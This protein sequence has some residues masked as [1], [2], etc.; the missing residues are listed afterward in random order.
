M[1][2][3]APRIPFSPADYLAWEAE[4]PTRHEYL[5]GE[6]FAMT[7]ASD[8]HVTIALNLGSLLRERLRGSPCRAYMSDMKLQVKACNAFFYPDVLV[9]CHTDDRALRQHK[10]RPSFLAEVLS[11]TT[12][13]LD[14]GEKF[15]C[16]RS[17]A[18]LKEYL[19]IDPGRFTAELF[20]LDESGHWVLY[21]FSLGDELELR[22]LGLRF[23]VTLLFED[24]EP[25][26]DAVSHP[27]N[28]ESSVE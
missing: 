8:A 9:S 13:R 19:I 5:N 12:E 25:E 14:R 15:A 1:N 3:L 7:G 18:S 22:S 28:H 27:S 10:E 4:Q 20:R 24:V 21:P 17:L 23:P 6:V 16:F 26:G 2:N 11:P